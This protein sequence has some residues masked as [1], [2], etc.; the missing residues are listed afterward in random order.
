MQI[1]L[2]ISL[3][4]FLRKLGLLCL[5]GCC[6]VGSQLSYASND[7]N[8]R[9]L[10]ATQYLSKWRST[11]QR[12]VW[13]YQHTASDIMSG[14]DQNS[15]VYKGTLIWGQP[16]K[17]AI[18]QTS[19]DPHIILYHNKV[20]YD[21][22][23]DLEQVIKYK[24]QSFADSP[25][26]NFLL[27]DIKNNTGLPLT[28]H[29]LKSGVVMLN[30]TS[31]SEGS[32]ASLTLKFQGDVLQNIKWVDKLSQQHILKLTVAKRAWPATWLKPKFPAGTEIIED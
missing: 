22:D 28:L 27:S 8:C 29:C 24:Q 4:M 32:E 15:E 23:P 16:T 12:M 9:G 2:D 25:F 20:L 6:L 10:T 7:N 1:K 19:P 17:I 3:K 11:H 26:L 14:S 18:H 30:N 5:F 31:D 13:N 21:Y